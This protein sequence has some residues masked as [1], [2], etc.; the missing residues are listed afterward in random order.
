MDRFFASPSGGSDEPWFR[1]GTVEVTTTILIC[2]L[3]TASMVLWAVDPTLVVRLDLI[4]PV[5]RDGQVWRLITWPL[6]NEASLGGVLGIVMMFIF[7]REVERSL[8]RRRY[9]W[10]L[11]ALVV[12]PAAFGVG[13]DISGFGGLF[14]L[15]TAMFLVFIAA[16]PTAMGFFG[17][18]LWVFGAVFI[19]IQVLQLTAVRAWEWLLVMVVDIAIS[20]LGARAMGLSSLEW[21]PRVP[22][23]ASLSG[24]RRSRRHPGSRRSGHRRGPAPVTPIR[25]V[26]TAATPTAADLLRQA[27]IDV[28]LDKISEHGIDSLSAA[29]RRRLDELSKRMRDDPR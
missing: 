25:P 12:I 23:P 14:L 11:A 24:D 9:L 6:A 1:V 21:I 7:G 17:I 2:A 13:L 18:P 22:L 27:E 3:A 10:L 15:E 8:G 19:G 28:L 20:F 16:Y 4:S 29:E 5:I 26:G